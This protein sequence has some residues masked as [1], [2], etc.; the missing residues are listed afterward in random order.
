M[1]TTL[2]FLLSFTFLFSFG[3]DEEKITIPKGIVY[4]YCDKKLVEKARNLITANLNDNSDYSLSGQTLIVGPVLWNRFKKIDV[5]KKIEGGNT[6]F[7]VDKEELKGKLTQ[8]V[9]DTKKVWAEL[10]K[11]ING[12]SFVIRKLNERE[13]IYY[14]SIISFDIDEPLL[15][16]ETKDHKYILNILK[17]K[18]K[19]MW[20]DEAP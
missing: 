8:D 16:V 3:Q 13:L 6:T 5:L 2:L 14:W 15:I 18:M 1:K 4:K 19:L 11:E 7:I 17:D 10:R 9:A 12:Q 20:L